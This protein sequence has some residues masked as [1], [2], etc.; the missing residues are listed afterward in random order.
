MV[1]RGNRKMS[2]TGSPFGG[3]NA[4]G[5]V[6]NMDCCRSYRR[7]TLI[8]P[9][10]DRFCVGCTHGSFESIGQ[11]RYEVGQKVHSVFSVLFYGKT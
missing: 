3:G 8:Q 5:S 6:K 9:S 2:Q 7:A 1:R 11:A 10:R 4:T